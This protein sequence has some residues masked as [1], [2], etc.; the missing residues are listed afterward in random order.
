MDKSES[1]YQSLESALSKSTK[2]NLNDI[3]RVSFK[4]Y[5][6]EKNKQ[7]KSLIEKWFVSTISSRD[8]NGVP[9]SL[10]IDDCSGMATSLYLFLKKNNIPCHLVI[11]DMK[12]FGELEYNTSYEYLYE[13]INGKEHQTIEYHVWVVIENFWIV[14][15]TF[16]LKETEKE[17]FIAGK[18]NSGVY[19]VDI[20]KV[21]DGLEYIPMLVGV[22]LLTTTNQVNLSSFS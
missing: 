15:P 18:T 10:T 17:Q 9:R 2:F 20:E 19:I 8:T 7:L 13:I 12:I 3:P 4:D 6:E 16:R 14:D 1:F 21:P 22:E 11:G 5:P